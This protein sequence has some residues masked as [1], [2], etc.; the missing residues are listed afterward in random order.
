MSGEGPARR[1]LRAGTAEAHERL[2]ARF[3]RFDLAD[4]DDYARFLTAHASALPAVERALDAGGMAALL[5]DWPARRRAGLIAADLAALGR[6]VPPPLPAPVP[7]D[8]AALWGAAYVVEGS[9]LGGAM[10]A[11]RVGAGLPTGYLATPLPAGAW[12]KFLAALE[13]ALYS[14]SMRASATR[15]ALATF[16]IFS[17][18]ADEVAR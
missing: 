11:R 4:A 10:L 17:H 16:A 6:P 15:S 18:A 2:D 14:D 8:P 12:R 3:G 7:A 13:N 9:R 1:M 5:D